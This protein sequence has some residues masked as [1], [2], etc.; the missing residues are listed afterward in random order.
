MGD[1]EVIEDEEGEDKDEGEKRYRSAG[2][3]D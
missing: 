1:G 3:S 2:G